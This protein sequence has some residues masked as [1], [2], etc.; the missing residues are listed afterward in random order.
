MT[1]RALALLALAAVAATSACSSKQQAPSAESGNAAS[2]ASK[3]DPEASLKE[4]TPDEVDA[5]I[6]KNDTTFH[7]YDSNEEEVFKA[8][9]V[10]GAKWV[11]FDAVT[12]DMLPPSKSDTLVFYC[13]N[14]H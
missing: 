3:A 10:P 13:A 2:S 14:P 5:R 11:P 1:R 12:A 4:M 6:A 9:H 8:G 7:A